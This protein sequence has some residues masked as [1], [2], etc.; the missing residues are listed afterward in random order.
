MVV[1][2]FN[3][4]GVLRQ[5]AVPRFPAEARA[6]LHITEGKNKGHLLDAAMCDASHSLV[7]GVLDTT[8]RME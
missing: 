6:S 4:A 3:Q 1:N 8:F 2:T 5:P 7:V